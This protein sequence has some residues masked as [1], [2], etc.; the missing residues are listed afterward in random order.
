MVEKYQGGRGNAAKAGGMC[1][2]ARSDHVGGRAVNTIAVLGHPVFPGGGADCQPD[3]GGIRTLCAGLCGGCGTGS[4]RWRRPVGRPGGGG[5]IHGLCTGIALSCGGGADL[6]RRHCLPGSEAAGDEMVPASDGGGIVSGGQRYLCSSI[7]GTPGGAES[8]R[9][10]S[11]AGGPGSVVLSAS[12]VARQGAPG[13]GQ[14]AVS[15][16]LDLACLDRPGAAGDFCGQSTAVC[17]AAVHCLSAGNHGRRGGRI[18]DRPDS[19]LSDRGGGCPLRRG[20]RPGGTPGRQPQRPPPG[21]SGPGLFGSGAGGP[22][23]GQKCAGSATAAGGGGR[24]GAV[25]A[26]AGPGLR[27]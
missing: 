1:C 26:A 6:V 25:F 27:W 23:A 7:P 10:R 22:A 14:P 5:I 16:G 11:G 4:C 24:N 18:G 9:S 12:A 15:D 13:A 17:P 20:L 8:L 3:A 21:Y 2:A 19:G